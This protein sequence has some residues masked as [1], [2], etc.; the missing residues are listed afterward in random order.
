MIDFYNAFVSYRHAPLDSKVAETL[1]R[2][3][4][5]FHV[6]HAIRRQTGRQKIERIFRD[7]DELP[8]TSDL[9]ETISDAL[10]KAEYLIV[11]CSPNTRESAWVP[12]EIEYFLKSHSRDKVL[13]VLAGGEPEDVIP[14]ILKRDGDKIIEP[15]SCDYRLPARK[16]KKEELPRL[17][18]ALIGC[19]YDE[20][21]RRERAYKMRQL[22]IVSSIV[23]AAAVGFAVYMMRSR[24]KLQEAYSDSLRQQ[25]L[26]LAS[27]S[28][29]YLD[30]DKRTDAV[31]NSLISV[32][33]EEMPDRPVTAEAV[34]VLADGTFAY[35]GLTRGSIDAVW[36]YDTGEA[37]EDFAVNPSGTRLAL[38]DYTKI[39]VWDVNEQSLVSLIQENFVLADRVLFVDD[40]T[41]IVVRREGITAYNSSEGSVEW[42]FIPDSSYLESQSVQVSDDGTIFFYTYS[43]SVIF[44]D[45]D[46]DVEHEIMLSDDDRFESI[47][48]IALSPDGEKIAFSA[49]DENGMYLVGCCDIASERTV[50]SEL[51]DLFPAAI[52]WVGDDR[53]AAAFHSSA[54]A[55]W[56]ENDSYGLEPLNVTVQCFNSSDMRPEWTSHHSCTFSYQN[57]SFVDLGSSGL[58]GF[59]CGDRFSAYDVLTGELVHMWDAGDTIVDAGDSDGDGYPV[60]ITRSG[61]YVVPQT[62]D[63]D[64]LTSLS[65]EF[66][67]E[68]ISAITCNGSFFVQTGP[69]TVICYEMNVRDEQWELV[70]DLGDSDIR[71]CCIDDSVIAVMFEDRDYNARIELIDPSDNSSVARVEIGSFVDYSSIDLLGIRNGYLYTAATD[72]DGIYL[73]RTDITNGNTNTEQLSG[74][75]AASLCA[76]SMT[77]KYIVYQAGRGNCEGVGLYDIDSGER[78]E[79]SVPLGDTFIGMSPVYDHSMNIIYLQ[80]DDGDYIVD[81]TDGEVISVEREPEW[82]TTTIVCPDPENERIF[83]SD[84]MSIIIVDLEGNKIGTVNNVLLM[85]VGIS[86][87][88]DTGYLLIMCI[89][90]SLLI[91]DA[92]TLEVIGLT[93]LTMPSEYA[94]NVSFV[95]DNEN[96]ILY[97][98]IGDVL[99]GLDLDSM[100]EFADIRRCLGYHA[101]SDRFFTYSDNEETG[102][103]V[104]FFRHYT[105]QDLIDRANDYLGMSFI[106]T[107]P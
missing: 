11:I 1:Q 77:D 89:D 56:N 91:Y 30:Q 98:Q 47:N 21:V 92:Q 43:G 86:V 26:N 52:T 71:E 41:L 61:G 80:T 95:Y 100:T 54:L 76:A 33:S 72:S 7:K 62:D 23:T 44:I 51:Y 48:R 37:I 14:D 27:E 19:S 55:Y 25:V 17:A 74:V 8:I 99:D 70:S 34:S 53:L 3:L 88:D 84:G 49:Y 85:P 13:T 10:T 94:S 6:P 107:V 5:R 28:R 96:N 69:M 35:Q 58:L 46:G 60:M 15:L 102:I 12:K 29:L 22:V 24:R 83:I 68:I 105:L 81:V 79:F 82:N 32:P 104:G 87:I 20:L 106:E 42:E 97:V 16:A 63:S 45:S 75:G 31:L 39:V 50:I 90:G 59:S 57:S 78:Q 73:I 103:S 4:E 18:A 40:D 65:Y 93:S 9:T 36:N 64:N 38:M 66:E 67:G 2:D 101:A